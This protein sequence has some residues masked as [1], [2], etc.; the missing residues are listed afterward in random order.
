MADVVQ[1]CI[2]VSM[3]FEDMRTKE[4]ILAILLLEGHTWEEDIF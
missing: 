1:L 2:C 3:M 4:E